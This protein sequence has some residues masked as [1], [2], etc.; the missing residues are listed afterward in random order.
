[1]GTH[2]SRG[3]L[4]R[5]ASYAIPVC[6]IGIAVLVY[7]STASETA[8]ALTGSVQIAGSETIRPVIAAC[9]EEFMTRNPAADVVVKGGGSGDGIAALLHGIVDIGM[10]SRELSDRE[11]A[12]A[13]AQ[14]I[15]IAM[16]ELGLDGI[17][18]IV[19]RDNPIAALALDRIRDV[20][21]G[22]ITSWRAL[23]GADADIEA[24]ARAEGSG[25][26][27]LFG[28]RVLAGR[29][30]HGTVRQL[31]TNE[32]IVREVAARPHAIG[33]TSLGALR[34]ARDGI[35]VVSLHSDGRASPV[36][37]SADTVR[38][39]RYPLTRTLYLSVAG[40]PSGVVRAFLDFCTTG[41]GRALV[42][43]AGYVAVSSDVP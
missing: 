8:P 12:Y 21:V 28:E 35:R 30:Y 26:A 3:G 16:V 40:A 9:A 43:S 38:S 14:G 1:M 19:H 22:T 4:G 31:P 17:T 32:A 20:F 39:R 11:R 41:G 5:L 15:E 10:I 29:S 18:I 7:A 23:G 33:Y 6:V 34:A 42:Q 36:S 13:A 27:V 24:L 2:P 37:P 25:T